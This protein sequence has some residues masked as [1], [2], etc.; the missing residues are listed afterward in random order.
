V[1]YFFDY[2]TYI[3]SLLH[4][5]ISFLRKYALQY[6]R[7]SVEHGFVKYIIF[8]PA[9]VEATLYLL[10]YALKYGF[11]K[12]IIFLPCTHRSYAFV[13]SVHFRALSRQFNTANIMLTDSTC[14]HSCIELRFN[15]FTCVI[16]CD[17]ESSP[18]N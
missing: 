13:H 10:K 1:D 3:R 15:V 11:V 6:G 4:R 5:C 17:T 14:L 18:Q 12:Y 2:I 9:P 7:P 8:Y 16:P